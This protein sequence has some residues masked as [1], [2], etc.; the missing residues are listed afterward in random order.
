[1]G[2]EIGLSNTTDGLFSR[3]RLKRISA[4]KWN[5]AHD[6]TWFNL[7]DYIPDFYDKI[8]EITA[9]QSYFMEGF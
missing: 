3:W 4:L 2:L 7:C 8:T 1:M 5:F 9:P 6:W